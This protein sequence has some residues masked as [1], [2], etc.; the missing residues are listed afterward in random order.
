MRV[1]A[2]VISLESAKKMIEVGADEIYLG[3]NVGNMNNISYTGRGNCNKCNSQITIGQK[4]LSEIVKYAHEHNVNVSYLANLPQFSVPKDDKEMIE[5]AFLEYIDIGLQADVDCI[6]V[7]DIGEMLLLKERGIKKDFI[8]SVY[9]STLN[10]EQLKFLRDIG[11]S[12]VT[13]EYHMLIN[14]IEELCK[15]DGIDIEVFANFGGSHLNGRC[16]MYHNIGEKFDIGFPCKSTYRIISES[17]IDAKCNVFDTNLYCSLC[18][19]GVLHKAGVEVLKITGRE[20]PAETMQMITRTYKSCAT[21]VENG[22][23]GLEAKELSKKEVE[24]YWNKWCSKR[25]CKYKHNNVTKYY[26]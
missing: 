23:N 25:R 11:F 9:L 22:M 16:S 7:A 4:E 20:L 6:V 10:A 12:R 21:H 5:K 14:E 8:G 3:A 17:P 2:P 15:V 24:G 1:K 18:N 19:I 26:V 13:L